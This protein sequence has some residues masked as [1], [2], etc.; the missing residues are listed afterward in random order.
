MARSVA[1]RYVSAAL[2]AARR[3]GVRDEMGAQL[4]SLRALMDASPA[5]R[6]LLGHPTMPLERKLAALDELL[7]EPAVEP[8]RRLTALL[9][10][11][12][13]VDVLRIAD[14]VYRELLD[15]A[16]GVLRAFVTTPVPLRDDQAERLARAMSR[17]LGTEVVVDA[18][19]DPDALGGIVVRVGDRVLD[20]SLRGRLDRIQR[21]MAAP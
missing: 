11:N 7:D 9:I 12:D 20:A 1:R 19:V 3:A 8:L 10:D 21:A 18:E 15:E 5:L 16:E 14:E 17:W 6:R 4:A 2:Q 13:R